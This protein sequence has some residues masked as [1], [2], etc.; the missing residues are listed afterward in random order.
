MPLC[1]KCGADPGNA[2][3]C[4]HCGAQQGAKIASRPV[5]REKTKERYV[6]LLGAC[7]CCCLSPFVTFLY[8]YFTEPDEDSFMKT[9]IFIAIMC[10]AGIGISV[11]LFLLI[12]ILSGGDAFNIF[13]F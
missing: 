1:P 8:Y 7:L 10:V 4:P 3:F 2:K 13:D 5:Y 6:P 12:M 11:G 9:F